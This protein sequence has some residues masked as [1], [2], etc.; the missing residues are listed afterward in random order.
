MQAAAV[1]ISEPEIVAS[2][3]PNADVLETK[4]SLSTGVDLSLMFVQRTKDVCA[5]ACSSPRSRE[6]FLQTLF[7]SSSDNTGHLMWS[8]TLFSAELVNLFS[9]YLRNKSILEIGCGTGG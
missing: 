6:M 5:L 2:A 4:I 1:E 3:D 9:K 7:E 8:G